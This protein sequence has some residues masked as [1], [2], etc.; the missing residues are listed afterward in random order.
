MNEL[1]ILVSAMRDAGRQILTMQNAGV[2][3]GKK[4]NNDIVTQADL[5][6][7]D[8]LK[9][10]LTKHFPDYGWLSEESVDD[11]QRLTRGKTWVVDPIDGTKEYAA[12]MPEY[13]VSVAL[14]ENGRPILASVYNPATEEFF[15]ASKNGGT[16]LNDKRVYCA[17]V[18]SSKEILIL[19]SRSEY[20]RGEWD[21]I[22]RHYQVQQIGSIAYK[23]A[24]VAGGKAHATFSLGPKSEWDVAAGVL[25]VT[26]AGGIATSAHEQE[27]L[28]N[29]EQVLVDGIVATEKNINKEIFDLIKKV[30][31]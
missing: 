17:D 6:A 1:Q 21:E 18:N 9:H 19:A 13:A 14:V 31:A 5:L 15:Y 11:A 23:L 4:S 26:E 24:L 2:V 20:A 29:R 3:V 27:M 16:W 7:N 10:Q 22:A 12:G 30:D 8:I 25:L 28:F